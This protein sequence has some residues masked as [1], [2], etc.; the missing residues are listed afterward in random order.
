LLNMKEHGRLGA[1]FCTTHGSPEYIRGLVTG[2]GF[3]AFMFAS[4][5]LGSH[6]LSY[7][8]PPDRPVESLPRNQHEIFPLCQKHDVGVMIMKPL[9]GG[10]LCTSKAFP[11]RHNWRSTLGGTTAGDILRSILI[12]PEVACVLPGTA[13]VEE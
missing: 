9:G 8:P 2:G 13:S 6:L 11:P 10:L 7:P 5:S 12:H 1:I 4:N 3:D